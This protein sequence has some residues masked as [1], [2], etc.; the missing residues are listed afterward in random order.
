LLSIIE[1]KKYIFS[2]E[3]NDS[4]V[5][6]QQI[7]KKYVTNFYRNLFG[8]T[9]SISIFLDCH[10]WNSCTQLTDEQV[11][12]LESFFIENEIKHAVFFSCDSNKASDPDGPNKLV[13]AF[14][15]LIN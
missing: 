13:N 12:F 4:M 9:T 6:D 7:L 10:F 8:T 3:I 2:L 5:F 15:I 11:A 1:G 14:Y